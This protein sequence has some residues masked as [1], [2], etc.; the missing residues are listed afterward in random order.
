[1][2]NLCA[3]K[4]KDINDNAEHTKFRKDLYITVK[5]NVLT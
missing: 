4:K 3:N 2:Q 1:M 5:I